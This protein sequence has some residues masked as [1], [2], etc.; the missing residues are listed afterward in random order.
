MT[1]TSIVKDEYLNFN[2]IMSEK[3]LG[4][5]SIDFYYAVETDIDTQSFRN[6][7]INNILE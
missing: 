3:Y 2:K 5:L 1:T 6:G 4:R 7:R